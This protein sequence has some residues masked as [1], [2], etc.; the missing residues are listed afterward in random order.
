M[1]KK[2]RQETLHYF[3]SRNG[4]VHPN[5]IDSL[6]FTYTISLTFGSYVNS[7]LKG[8]IYYFHCFWRYRG[9]N[10]GVFYHQA[11]PPALFIFYF[12]KGVLLKCP[13]WLLTCDP[14]TLNLQIHW[15][16]W[17][18]PS[19]WVKDILISRLLTLVEKKYSKL[20]IW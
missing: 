19:C 5:K 3:H 9:L 14:P 6:W 20:F 1:D 11:T 10:L 4:K 2:E 18:G 8:F 15:D 7:L 12:E 13:G 17:P 16:Y